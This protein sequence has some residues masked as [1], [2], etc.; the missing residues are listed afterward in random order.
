MTPQD[1]PEARI[2]EIDRMFTRGSLE[3]QF[4]VKL[5]RRLH[6]QAQEIERLNTEIAV[7]REACP[8]GR[9]Q[10]NFDAPLL[11]LVEKEVS[12]GFWLD[13]QIS[14]MRAR[15]EAAES[16]LAAARVVVAQCKRVQMYGAAYAAREALDRLE[17]ELTQG[18]TSPS[19]ANG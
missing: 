13:S 15:A 5:S 10:Q 2:A 18:H 19:Q 8:S 16:A 4:V 17:W 12:R 6:E 9:Q 11:A 3:W 1:S 14:D 7:A